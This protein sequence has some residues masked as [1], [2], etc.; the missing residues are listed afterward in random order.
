MIDESTFFDKFDSALEVVGH[1][2]RGYMLMS[3]DVYRDW[4][5]VRVWWL[6]APLWLKCLRY[7]RLRLR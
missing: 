5:E 4:Q 2:H 7:V 6:T 1:R 3:P